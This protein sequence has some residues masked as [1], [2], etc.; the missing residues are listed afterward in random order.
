MIVWLKQT[1]TSGTPDW[2]QV[3]LT[4]PVAV[5]G[6]ATLV[7][8]AEHGV[9]RAALVTTAGTDVTLNGR[10][11]LGVTVLEERAELVG[12]GARLVFTHYAPAEP[13]PLPPAH[14]GAP[15]SRCRGTLEAGSP[16]VRCPACRAW[17][18]QDGTHPCWSYDPHT[19]CC[20]HAR[21]VFAWTPADGEEEGDAPT[22]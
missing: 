12:D 2:L 18:H 20:G 6:S 14:A 4:A 9:A 16:C 19:G 7:P 17:A 13:V 3:P 21:A 8:F 22:R 1:S 10:S 11:P 15:C 5:A